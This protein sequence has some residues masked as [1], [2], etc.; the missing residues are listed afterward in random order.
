MF[1]TPNGRADQDELSLNIEKPIK[2]PWWDK[3]AFIIAGIFSAVW[4][5]FIWDYL[6]SSGW[7]SSRHELSPAEFIGGLCGLFLPIIISILVGSY[8]DRTSQIS[9]EAQ[10]LRSYL[11]D[12]IYPT[13]TNALY[14]RTL[15]NALRDQVQEFKKIY[16]DVAI[17]TQDLR[18]NLQ[19][20]SN[21]L[22]KTVQQLNVNTA[23]NIREMSESI[24]NLS[25]KSAEACKQASLNA[26]TFKEQA[27]L[28]QRATKDAGQKFS[29]A[30]QELKTY[31]DELKKVEENLKTA[32]K[33]THEIL[34]QTTFTSNQIE[35]KIQHIENLIKSYISG[36]KKTDV[37]LDEKIKQAK[38]ILT[39][40]NE[41]LEKTE[42]FLKK[43]ENAVLQAQTALRSH[44][45]ALTQSENLIKNHQEVLEKSLTVSNQKIKDIDVAL[46]TNYEKIIQTVDVT[47]SRLKEVNIE[48]KETATMQSEVLNNPIQKTEET[49]IKKP[50]DFLQNAT[51]ILDR[52][53]SFSIDMAHIFTPKS[54]ETLWKKY[55]DG[56]KAVFMR[57]ITKMISE[58]QH[59]QIKE[60][61]TQNTDFNQSVVRYMNEFEQM[62]KMV[63]NE[64][65]NKLLMSI[66]IGSDIGRLYMVLADV[67]K[68][69][70][71]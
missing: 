71:A 28:F 53:Q 68:R 6:F 61:Y 19:Q 14:T 40:Q 34:S 9:F 42:A 52:L 7:W 25:K 27:L 2:Q 29:P 12:L 51:A 41:A 5:A 35:N 31:A 32:D 62:T 70:D 33:H 24:E 48:L 22:A 64:D 18:A 10:T 45:G 16:T 60:L 58:S 13:N 1:V 46:K 67:L 43:H 4:L 66:L 17:Q 36:S 26:T 50:V 8:F 65:E 20:W 44:N 55:Y 23:T 3:K 11:N 63:Q 21:S 69:Q 56:D 57:H 38:L 15:T 30:L 37:L 47:L 49:T 59:K 54:E 39:T